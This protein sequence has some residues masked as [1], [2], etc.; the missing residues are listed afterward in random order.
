MRRWWLIWSRYLKPAWSEPGAQMDF[1]IRGCSS[2]S[3]EHSTPLA[4]LWASPDQAVW[5]FISY[6]MP[7]EKADPAVNNS[8]P[9]FCGKLQDKRVL[10]GKCELALELKCGH[11]A[12]Q[13][14]CPRGWREEKGHCRKDMWAQIS[15]GETDGKE[16]GD[17]K[18]SEAQ[19][20]A[21]ESLLQFK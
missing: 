12:V 6:K 3:S 15:W 5:S 1:P 11:S 14:C 21:W 8:N 19:E 9:K 10:L 20:E 4:G 17:A 18:G 2:Y 13:G 16:K 7:L